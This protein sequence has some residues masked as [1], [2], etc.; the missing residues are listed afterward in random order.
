[1]I[2]LIHLPGV[3]VPTDQRGI[4]F[5]ETLS[6]SLRRCYQPKQ[7]VRVRCIILTLIP[8]RHCSVIL[9]HLHHNI[10]LKFIC[11]NF[12]PCILIIMCDSFS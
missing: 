7:L 1:M 8:I 5:R 9:T 11:V 3:M 12:A 2:C 4:K 6:V 10:Q